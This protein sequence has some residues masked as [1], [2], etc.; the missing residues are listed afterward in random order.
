M[1]IILDFHWVGRGRMRYNFRLRNLRFMQ[2]PSTVYN[3]RQYL[4]HHVVVQQLESEHKK[5]LLARF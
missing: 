1:E 5:S 3:F 4:L 2:L